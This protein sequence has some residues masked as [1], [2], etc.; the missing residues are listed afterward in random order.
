MKMAKAPCLVTLLTEPEFPYKKKGRE[1]EQPIKD[2][3]E[4]PPP[5]SPPQ[6]PP[7]PN[8]PPLG[9]PGTKRFTCPTCGKVF[10][11]KEELTM[12]VETTHLTTKK[13]V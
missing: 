9:Y 11:T 6:P 12:H 3:I 10:N 1:P 8:P 7:P 4:P 2:S 5:E 13:K